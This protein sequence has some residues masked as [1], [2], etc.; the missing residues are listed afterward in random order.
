MTSHDHGAAAGG[1]AR[2]QTAVQRLAGDGKDAQLVANFHAK[3][4]EVRVLDPACGS[5]NVLYVTLEMMKRPEGEVSFLLDEVAEEHTSFITVDPNQFVGI[6]LNHRAAIVADLV[7]W[8]GY[9]QW[10]PATMGRRPRPSLCCAISKISET[11][12]QCWNGPGASRAGDVNG[13]R[14]D[15]IT[16]LRHIVRG[17][18][19]L[20]A[21]AQI[22]VYDDATPRLTKWPETELS[23][24]NPTFIGASRLRAALTMSGLCAKPTPRWRNLR[25]W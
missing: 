11:A 19:V 9:L 13:A 10:R 23:V 15:G 25:I 5:G 24:G 16:T 18:E 12:V 7:L 1:L 14:R 3:L 22:T 21:S 8:I 20:D 2:C 17:E 6:E 4:C